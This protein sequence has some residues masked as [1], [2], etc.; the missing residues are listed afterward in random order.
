MTTTDP[1]RARRR[2][3]LGYPPDSTQESVPEAAADTGEKTAPTGIG[4]ALEGLTDQLFPP[5]RRRRRLMLGL[6]ETDR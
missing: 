2:M 4:E 6:K 1:G 3:M 5:A